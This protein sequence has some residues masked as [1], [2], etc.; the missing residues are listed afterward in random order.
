M[1]ESW[2][3]L[4]QRREKVCVLVAH[5]NFILNWTHDMIKPNDLG[6]TSYAIV[7]SDGGS[8]PVAQDSGAG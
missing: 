4:L 7:P 3:K 2:W 1:L 5:T 8:S 6:E